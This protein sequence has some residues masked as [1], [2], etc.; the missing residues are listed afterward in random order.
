M[1]LF[2]LSL[3]LTLAWAAICHAVARDRPLRTFI[4][5]ASCGFVV[6]GIFSLSL[7]SVAGVLI[8]GGVGAVA[9][10]ASWVVVYLGDGLAVRL[11]SALKTSQR[12]RVVAAVVVA[13]IA[14]SAIAYDLTY[15]TRVLRSA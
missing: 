1:L 15:A 9:T 5:A 11:I 13:V 3:P 14:A 7:G 12:G 6:G 2:Y 4:A 10:S 8:L